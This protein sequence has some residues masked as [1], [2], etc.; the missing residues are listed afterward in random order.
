[1]KIYI[2]ADHA[3]FELKK[4]LVEYLAEAGLAVVDLG[5]KVFDPND[6]YPDFIL[7]LAQKV[8]QDE[9]SKGIIIGRTGNGEAIAANKV[10]GIRAALCL[11]E[12]M[13]IKARQD[14]DANILSLGADFVDEAEA[15]RVVDAFLKTPFS[16]KERHKR[17]LAKIAS[18]EQN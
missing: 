9:E 14:N 3:G 15:E 12:K 17:R 8:A 11:N 13:A 18:F 10:K 1:M 6:D 4:R 16:Q 2:A 5:N 7:P